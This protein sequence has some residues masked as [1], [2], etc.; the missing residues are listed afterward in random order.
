MFGGRP[1]HAPLPSMPHWSGSGVANFHH[2]AARSDKACEAA[3]S[4]V[5]LDMKDRSSSS[6]ALLG[7]VMKVWQ[8]LCS[9]IQHRPVK[10]CTDDAKAK[11]T[12]KDRLCLVANRCICDSCKTSLRHM[13][14]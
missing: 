2:L 3:K 13:W 11:T 10:A 1:S 8:N 14:G 5:S 9:N 7:H 12:L 6:S 4:V